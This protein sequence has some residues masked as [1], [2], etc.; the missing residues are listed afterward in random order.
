MRIAAA[1]LQA[2]EGWLTLIPDKNVCGLV[3]E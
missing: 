1:E 2:I 3:D